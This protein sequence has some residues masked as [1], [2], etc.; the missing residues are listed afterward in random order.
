MISVGYES[1]LYGVTHLPMR[2]LQTA[3][4]CLH[5][6]ESCSMAGRVIDALL[7]GSNSNTEN[8]LLNR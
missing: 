3:T 1:C 7:D 2:R 5:C 8:G 6:L 4:Q